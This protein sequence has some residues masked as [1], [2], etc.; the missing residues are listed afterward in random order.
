MGCFRSTECA[1]FQAIFN[2]FF[3]GDFLDRCKA[4]NCGF[5]HFHAWDEVYLVIP[6]LVLG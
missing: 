4:I 3:E 6:W 5:L 2:V 1:S